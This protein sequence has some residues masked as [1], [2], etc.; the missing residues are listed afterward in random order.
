MSAEPK[1]GFL[2]LA[3]TYGRAVIGNAIVVVAT[4]VLSPFAIGAGAL[5]FRAIA[6]S[7]CLIWGRL[8]LEAYGVRVRVTGL[9]NFPPG[10]GCLLLFNHQSLFDIPVLYGSLRRTVRF[11]AKVELFKIPLFGPA[12]RAVGTLPI[13]RDNREETLRIYREAQAKFAEGFSFALA[14]EGTR[15]QEPAI[16]KFKAGPFLFAIGAQAPVL[17]AVIKGA[18]D[19][20]PKSRLTPNLGRWRRTIQLQLLPMVPT[21]GLTN[22]DLGPL[23]DRVRS[24]MIESFARL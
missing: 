21:R 3:L 13:A 1:P 6:D 9:E 12:M 5:G 17:P 2:L 14:P 19:V 18:H 22:A 10:Q 15:Q 8:L 23:S 4:I 16:G 11:G 24:A 20:L 7:I